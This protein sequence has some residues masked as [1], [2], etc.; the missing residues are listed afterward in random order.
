MSVLEVITKAF[1]AV[2]NNRNVDISLV[3]LDDQYN[4]KTD[5]NGKVVVKCKSKGVM[6]VGSDG[7]A[8]FLSDLTEEES[9]VGALVRLLFIGNGNPEIYLPSRNSSL[10]Y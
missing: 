9:E 3:E 1:K 4:P 2:G 8:Y 6:R 5:E 7:E 10:F